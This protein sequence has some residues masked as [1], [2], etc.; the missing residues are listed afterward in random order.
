V[1]VTEAASR[2]M[3]Q[4]SGLLAAAKAI[5]ESLRS[6]YPALRGTRSSGDKDTFA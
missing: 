6:S 5:I 1:F 4:L 2:P 3:R